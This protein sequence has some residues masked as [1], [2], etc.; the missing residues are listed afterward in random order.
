MCLIV[1]DWQPYG[2]PSL[3]VAANRDEFHRRP[4]APLQV[5][6]DAP[7]VMA[8]RDQVSGGTWLGVST[9][10]RFAALT[11][12]R[13]PARQRPDA[14]SR[15]ALVADFLTG[16]MPAAEHAAACMREAAQYNGFNLLLCDGRD[17]IWVGHGGGHPPRSSPLP[18]GLHALSNHLPGTPWPKLVRAREAF[19]RVTGQGSG[20]ATEA[21]V[22][23]LFELLLEHTPAA[24]ADLPDTGVSLEWERRLSPVFIAG[25]DYGTRSRTVLVIDPAAIRI[26]E[27]RHG[28]GGGETGRTVLTAVR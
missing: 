22:D 21:R 11:N 25:D 1:L 2:H 4:S 14:R 9:D 13:D 19:A 15:G 7:Q 6:P 23:A 8:G 24:D 18:P 16:R 27:R 5:W 3:Q 12:Y 26:E 28:P 20:A 10:G 17:L